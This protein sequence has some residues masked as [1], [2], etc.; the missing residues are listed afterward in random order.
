[1]E[2][3][4]ELDQTNA[5][6][7]ENAIEAFEMAGKPIGLAARWVPYVT[8]ETINAQLGENIASVR[9][10][11]WR[12]SRLTCQ[13]ET[14]QYPEYPIDFQAE[15]NSSGA[16]IEVESTPAA[17]EIR[18]RVDA[19]LDAARL[20]LEVERNENSLIASADFN[21]SGWLPSSARWSGSDWSLTS[22]EF[23]WDSLYT[24][25]QF[26]L[27]GEWDGTSYRNV[28]NGTVYPDSESALKVPEIEFDTAISGDMNRLRL[29][30]LELIGPGLD[31]RAVEPVE[32]ELGLFQLD[33]ELAM[34]LDFDLALFGIENLSGAFEGESSL[35]ADEDGSPNGRFQLSGREIAYDDL[36]TRV[37]EIDALLYWP[38]I[39]VERMDVVLDSGS[40]IGIDGAVDIEERRLGKSV[41]EIDVSD[42]VSNKALPEGT[43]VEA[44]R[45]S[46]IAEGPFESLIHTGSLT[47]GSF[48]DEILKPLSLKL[49][50]SGEDRSFNR[51]DLSAASDEAALEFSGSSILDGNS[52]EISLSQLSISA[53]ETLLASLEGV[54]KIELQLDEIVSGTVHPLKLLGNDAHLAVSASFSYPERAE[55]QFLMEGV[56]TDVWIDTWLKSSAPRVSINALDINAR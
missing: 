30:S 16:T 53:K 20:E 38:V 39:R 54:S 28:L 15:F 48:Q 8:V 19:E 23:A 50:W 26:N 43:S 41:L 33:G 10:L 13:I 6:G 27:A 21:R 49:D 1:M 24:N 45:I 11:E 14:N 52:L 40:R 7:P 35:V 56:R 42:D 37:F 9:N 2:S 46:A 5:E 51:F 25:I 12:D 36:S 47:V 4:S 3:D 44:V 18:A 32:L 17:I 34:D 55:L 29:D 31:A 22:E